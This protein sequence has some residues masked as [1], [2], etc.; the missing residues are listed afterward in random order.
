MRADGP[1]SS[2]EI[3]KWSLE[4]ARRVMALI[5]EPNER[6][7]RALR[8]E[9]VGGFVRVMALTPSTPETQDREGFLGLADV[10]RT[11]LRQ[12]NSQTGPTDF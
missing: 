6:A 9:A 1:S 2:P 10:V 5:D 11:S 7:N 12:P 3:E 4:F 8:C